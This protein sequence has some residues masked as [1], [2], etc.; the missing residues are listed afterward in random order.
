[1]RLFLRRAP[2]IG[3]KVV[4]T[5]KYSIFFVITIFF[6]LFLHSCAFFAFFSLFIFHLFFFCFTPLS[7]FR[8]RVSSLTFLIDLGQNELYK[9]DVFYR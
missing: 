6:V 9:L 7:P 5:Q 1:M 4:G 2:Y 3:T 8:D